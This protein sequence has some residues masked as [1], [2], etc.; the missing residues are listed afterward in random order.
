MDSQSQS[1][2]QCFP[3]G[4]SQS[5]VCGPDNPWTESMQRHPHMD[6]AILR[7]KYNLSK[8]CAGKDGAL[9]GFDGFNQQ[10]LPKWDKAVWLTRDM[11]SWVTGGKY[12]TDPGHRFGSCQLRWRARKIDCC[13]KTAE[14]IFHAH[15]KARLK[16]ALREPLSGIPLISID[17]PFG[18]RRPLHSVDMY[19]IWTDTIKF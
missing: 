12:G 7:I 13:N 16:S 3:T 9:G 15:D 2:L 4:Q 1:A 14:V 11:I 6:G 18:P 5:F 10:E 19:W 17:E 8:Y